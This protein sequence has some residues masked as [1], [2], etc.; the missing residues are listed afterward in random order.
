MVNVYS[1]FMIAYAIVVGIRYTLPWVMSCL[2]RTTTTEP[3]IMSLLFNGAP[4][5][6]FVD[7]I[8]LDSILSLAVKPLVSNGDG[9]GF[10]VLRFILFGVSALFVMVVVSITPPWFTNSSLVW[11]IH[12]M[13]YQRVVV[14]LL[15]WKMAWNGLKWMRGLQW[16][17]LFVVVCRVSIEIWWQ[18]FPIKTHY[19][20]VFIIGVWILI[21]VS[22]YITTS[23]HPQHTWKE[24]RAK[25]NHGINS[26]SI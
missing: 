15:E 23:I 8:L 19:N 17:L 14:S 3:A 2:F 6:W 16:T 21:G 12:I 20:L 7:W 24:Y 1:I 11:L 26:Y 10:P 9:G 13:L 18:C 25:I 5:Y 22:F 4:S